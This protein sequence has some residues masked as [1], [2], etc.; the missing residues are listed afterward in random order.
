MKP[1]LW[2]V[3]VVGSLMKMVDEGLW[4]FKQNFGVASS[5]PA[6]AL[7]PTGTRTASDLKVFHRSNGAVG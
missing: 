3:T 1:S 6:P 4:S 5:E 7:R 2:L